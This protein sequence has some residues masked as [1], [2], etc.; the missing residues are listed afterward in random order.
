[1]RRIP[2]LTGRFN[3]RRQALGLASGAEAVVL[4]RT[5][6]ALAHGP[7]PGPADFETLVPPVQRVWVRRIA[8]L[9]LWVFYTFD[10]SVVSLVHVAD[11][12]PVPAD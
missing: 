9:N 10:D 11:K 3:R 4:A 7:L 6:G 8:G 1:M 2:R 12:P 5:I